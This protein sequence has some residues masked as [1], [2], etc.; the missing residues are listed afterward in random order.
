MTVDEENDVESF[1]AVTE[2]WQGLR[3]QDAWE[4]G[5]F[6]C[7]SRKKEGA[8]EKPESQWMVNWEALSGD[9]LCCASCTN[10]TCA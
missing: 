2:H 5:R 6:P 1:Y 8:Y 10:C 4:S 3:G 7:V 9:H